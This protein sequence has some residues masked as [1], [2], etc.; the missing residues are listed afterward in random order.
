MPLIRSLLAGFLMS[1][2]LVALTPAIAHACSCAVAGIGKQ[3][4]HA[5]AVFVGT[6]DEVEPPPWRPVMSS[7]DPATLHFHVTAVFKGDARETTEVSTA[8]E[9][10]SCGL[11]D[12]PVDREYVVVA[13]GHDQLAASLCGGTVETSDQNLEQVEKALGPPR[14]PADGTLAAPESGPDLTV[15]AL[16]GGAAVLLAVG[17]LVV[18]RRRSLRVQKHPQEG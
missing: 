3:A 6:L 17:A 4:A 1:L 18:V 14:P 7:G 15:W 8:V 2:G 9:G 16:A 11:G 12:L 10:S 5:D 13:Q